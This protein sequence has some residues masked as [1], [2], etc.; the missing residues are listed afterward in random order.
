MERFISKEGD[1]AEEA[2][3]SREQE[4]VPP[5]A[6]TGQIGHFI[7]RKRSTRHTA[8]L[9]DAGYLLLGLVSLATVTG[10]YFWLDVPLVAAAFTYLIV[11]VLLSLVSN[12]SSLIVLSFIGVGCLS[13][14]F[15]PP[16]YSFRVDYPQ[17]IITISAFVI[18]SFVVNFLVT[19]VRVERES[20]RD[21]NQR[22]EVTNEALRI[23]NL[24]RKR[25]EQGRRES[26]DK[27]RQIIETVPGLIWSAGPTGEPTHFNH[28]LLDYS[29]MRLE[30][31]QHGGWEA[32][33]HP[34]DFPETAR[35]FYRAIQTGTSYEA[36][37]RLRRSDGEYRW[38]HVRGEPLRDR[39][40]R[41]VQ[42]YGLS[43]DIDEGKKAEDRLRRS[44]M[45]LAMAQRLSQ[46]GSFTWK[47]ST[48]ERLWSDEIY[49][50]FDIDPAPGPD[51][52][53]AFERVDPDQ[54]DHI[55]RLDE[56]VGRG[57]VSMDEIIRLLFPDGSIKFIHLQSH[58]LR[59]DDGELEVVGALSDITKFKA[60]EDALRESERSARSAI[61]GIAGLVAILAPNGEIETVNRQ[62]FEYFGRSLEWLKNWG[63]ND[64]VHPEDLPRVLELVKGAMASG[65]PYNY[66]LRLRRFDGEYRWF[67]DRGVPI[68]DDSGR[69]A[70]WYVLL[71]DIEDR[72]RALARLEQMQSD[73]AHM[74]RVSMMGELAASLTHEITQPIAS[75]RNNARAAQNFL[76]KQPPDLSEI[77]EALGC[78]VG[79]ADR[80]GDIV[81][82][83]RDHIKKAP[84]RKEYFDLNEAIN[85]VIV[86][87]RGAIIKNGV[88]VQTR[89]SEGLSP[90][91]CDR[92]Q[93]QQVVLNL[94][95]NA[96]EAMG[97]VE[98]APR[99]LLISTEQHHTG[100]LVAV[101]DS[102][103]GIDPTNLERVFEAFYTTKS[104]G[105]GMG[106]SI[107]RSIVDAH[108]GR[109]W[110]EVNEPRGT[111]FQFTLPNAE[112]S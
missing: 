86:L 35:A 50:I 10:L 89:L 24:E 63:A 16:I 43:V 59:G 15:A 80:A 91:H 70:R 66:E 20:L 109:L 110:A 65:I 102:G 23:E 29:G 17:D 46:T 3:L 82:R 48:N 57:E 68:R 26:E 95:L 9:H 108:G 6:T 27:L 58:A 51:I 64:A 75:A 19:R 107:C 60:A 100:V 71:T 8:L 2:L 85:E 79:D 30:E 106:L 14:F 12:F 54:R 44:E 101:R 111:V 78:V 47:P 32:F 5:L 41:I 33:L 25:A 84:P 49:R 96:A 53:K 38:H 74:N 87:G 69:I 11:L 18:T 94:I 104:R 36:A 90:I 55:R 61:D 7:K 93:L 52:E 105:V 97:S 62:V 112:N 77:R 56:L 42:W 34:A 81:D 39:D 103:S 4:D 22:L 83:I 13:Y 76:D 67:D 72:T 99:D 31:F 28:R 88:W 92:V 37:H 73:F 21:A 40:G 1:G 45:H 98:G